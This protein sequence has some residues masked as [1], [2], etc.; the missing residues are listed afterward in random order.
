MGFWN[1]LAAVVSAPFVPSQVLTK[2]ADE[3]LKKAIVIG[4]G[5]VCVSPFS[6]HYR[7]DIPEM[8]VKNKK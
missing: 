3:I 6:S 7:H 2:N 1:S 4:I 8:L 5:P